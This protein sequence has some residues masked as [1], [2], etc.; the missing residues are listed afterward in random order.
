MEKK[1][2]KHIEQEDVEHFALIVINQIQE[3]LPNILNIVGIV[4]QSL[5]KKSNN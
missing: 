1:K 5:V 2:L 4:V 3:H